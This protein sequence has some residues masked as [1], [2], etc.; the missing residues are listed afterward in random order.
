[1]IEKER[2]V[3]ILGID[4]E[5]FEAL[6]IEKGA[7]L[8]LFEQQLNLIFSPPA[9]YGTDSYLRIRTTKNL[10]SGEEKSVLTLKINEGQE[11]IRT[12]RE[13]TTP[14]EDA[15]VMSE[16]L[17]LSGLR[18]PVEAQKIRKSYLLRGAVIDLDKWSESVYPEPYAE[19]EVSSEE[20]LEEILHLLSID[21]EQ[22]S[23]RSIRQLMH[24]VKKREDTDA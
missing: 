22:V 16:I 15:E 12:N 17:C 10:E 20:K 14:V 3:K 11:G 1:M 18:E 5:A 21:P 13:Y 24:D 6:L 19:I 7:T 8:R 2:E 9:L 4:L 23:T